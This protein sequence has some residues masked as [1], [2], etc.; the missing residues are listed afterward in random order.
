MFNAH[1]V[2]SARPFLQANVARLN[3]YKAKLIVFPRK[4]NQKPKKGDSSPAETSAATQVSLATAVPMPVA[5]DEVRPSRYFPTKN[6]YK[7]CSIITI[8]L[9]KLATLSY[10]S[11]KHRLE[12]N[13]MNAYSFTAGV[14]PVVSKRLPDYHGRRCQI[15]HV[16]SVWWI[17]A[18]P[19]WAWR[20]RQPSVP[21]EPR[22][23]SQSTLSS[24]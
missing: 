7:L 15:N 12:N 16:L 3:E 1:P 22:L 19:C 23:E 17:K 24:L 21:Q 20:R 11:L 6:Y 4:S 10:A 18:P 8:H 5:S 9:L 2:F 13:I 14:V